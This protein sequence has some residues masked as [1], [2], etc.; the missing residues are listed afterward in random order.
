M[1]KLKISSL[2]KYL[3]AIGLSLLIINICVGA[4][5]IKQS[6]SSLISLIQNRMLDISKTA[7]SMLDGDTLESLKAEDAET[8]NYKAV[9]KTL[10]HFQD[11]IDLKY[12]YCI[13][14]IGNNKFVFS[15]DPTIEDPGVFG[16][17][18]VTTDALVKAS[19][20]ES[21]VD[22][23]PY[24][25][26]WGRFYSSYSPVF[27][28]S[29][30]VAG[31]VAVDFSADW[32]DEQIANSVRTI[33][34]AAVLSL[35]VG[36]ILFILITHLSRKRFRY[37]FS[38]LNDLR[39]TIEELLIGIDKINCLKSID[40]NTKTKLSN[41]TNKKVEDIDTLKDEIDQMQTDLRHKIEIVHKQAF[42][43]RLTSL[44]NRAAYMETINSIDSHMK[45]EI[46]FSVAVFDICGLKNINDDLG[47]EAGDMAITDAAN[48]LKKVFDKDS[49]YRFGGDEF[50]GIFNTISEIE[51]L[52][53][54]SK[55]DKEILNYNKDNR[56]FK[57]PLNI[58]KGWS[59]Y[60]KEKDFS[61]RE[62]FKRADTAMY[63]DKS[64]YYKNHTGADRRKRTN[65]D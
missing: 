50:I 29:G 5:L 43:D 40:D 31:I 48:I 47:H 34:L 55:L 21:A 42:I 35:L 10:K 22:K 65:S 28:S 52:D 18:I 24:E 25:D 15:V 39:N 59:A 16:S 62:I 41:D 17:P 14:D 37:F 64:I 33:I 1:N 6:S 58:S 45:E 49:L 63:N 44:K 27:N 7:A 11:N 60:N 4:L 53:L 26:K 56:V 8:N 36:G 61:Y 57:F 51:M 3:L 9:M 54:F 46:P 2:A 38:Q 30:K 19:K 13:K 20:G 12:I 32:Y 23:E